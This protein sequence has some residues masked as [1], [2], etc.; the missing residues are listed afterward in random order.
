MPVPECWASIVGPDYRLV[1]VRSE[2]YVQEFFVGEWAGYIDSQGAFSSCSFLKN[3]F[4]HRYR[5]KAV[6]PTCI[7]LAA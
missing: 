2:G 5:G 1:V 6:W 3:S 7:E 4:D